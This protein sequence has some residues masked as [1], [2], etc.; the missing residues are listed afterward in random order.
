[1]QEIKLQFSDVNVF[2]YLSLK[3]K[4]NLFNKNRFLIYSHKALFEI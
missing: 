2:I 3:D 1:M 4:M